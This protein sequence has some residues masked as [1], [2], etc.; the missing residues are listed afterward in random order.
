VP[1]LIPWGDAQQRQQV[2]SNDLANFLQLALNQ[3]YD[4]PGRAPQR[5]PALLFE[6]AIM[7]TVLVEVGYLSNS[8]DSEHL[9]DPKFHAQL[10]TALAGG[11]LAYLGR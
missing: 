11:I 7:P 2:P 1:A 4:T 9:A 5:V 6:G 10:A 8:R 3:V